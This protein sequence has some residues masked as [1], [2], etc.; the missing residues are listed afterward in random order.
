MPIFYPPCFGPR[1]YLEAM[2]GNVTEWITPPIDCD[3]LA[4]TDGAWKYIW[5]PEGGV[6]QLFNLKNDPHELVNLAGASDA[7]AADRTAEEAAAAKKRL[8]EEL[9]TRHRKRNSRY[10]EN[11]ELPY[12]PEVDASQVGITG[13]RMVS[14]VPYI[15]YGARCQR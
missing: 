2:M 11:G 6:E 13:R 15:F 10:L 1:E 12:L 9:I 4:I 5:Y 14:A 7:A 3:Y 8:K